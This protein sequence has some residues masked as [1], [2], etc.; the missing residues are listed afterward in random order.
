M[1]LAEGELA[2]K[3]RRVEKTNQLEEEVEL[4]L[5]ECSWQLVLSILINGSPE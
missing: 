3:Q 4:A 1:G 2:L 5:A